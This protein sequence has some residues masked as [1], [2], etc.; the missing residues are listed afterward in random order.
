MA[1]KSP[2]DV[3]ELRLTGPERAAL[4]TIAEYGVAAIVEFGLVKFTSTT[5]R[6]ADML[7][8]GKSFTRTEA[9]ALHNAIAK[10]FTAARAFQL[11]ADLDL[12]RRA[13]AKLVAALD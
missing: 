8:T 6:A 3:I 13:E 7:Q 11:A 4:R 1:D 2:D 10:G 5:E 9:L 12:A